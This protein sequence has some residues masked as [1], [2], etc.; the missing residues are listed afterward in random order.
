MPLFILNH[1]Q[2]YGHINV[3]LGIA[4]LLAERGHKPYFLLRKCF[5]DRIKDRGYHFRSLDEPEEDAMI[6]KKDS[7]ALQMNFLESII[8]TLKK[9]TIEQLSVVYDAEY[10][11]KEHKTINDSFV[12][13]L[14]HETPDIIILSTLITLPAVETCGIPWIYFH[15]PSPHL[16]YKNLRL[17]PPLS[18]FSSD[19]DANQIKEFREALENWSAKPAAIWSKYLAEN[20]VGPVNC[21]FLNRESPYLNLYAYPR[22]LDFGDEYKLPSTYYRMDNAIRQ[23]D[24]SE[25]KIPDTFLQSKKGKLIYVSMGSW[26]SGI[27]EVMQKLV[28]ILA[29]SPNRFIISR[30]PKHDQYELADNMWGER[31]LN[32]LRVLPMVDL[33]I[34]HGGNNSTVECLYFG[35]P[36]IVMPCFFDQHDNAQR[37]HEK[38]L[39]IKMNPFQVDD[40]KL[41][42]AIEKLLTDDEIIAR[43]QK[44]SQELKNSNSREEVVKVLEQ[45][46]EKKVSPF[47][48]V[49]DVHSNENA[50]KKLDLKD[51]DDLKDKLKKSVVVGNNNNN[52]N[53]ITEKHLNGVK[54]G[55]SKDD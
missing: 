17:I 38:G 16:L 37:I 5:E 26:F 24:G 36:M 6:T 28:N 13:L 1:Y 29:K 52:H 32:Q 20:G 14:K 47:Q 11:M 42:D 15:T 33:V 48:I 22:I 34:T 10:L 23:D 40:D 49:E 4:D 18:G 54:N 53:I 41:L 39:G 35:K 9:P 30:G 25:L 46:A 21:G 3:A 55:K 7:A 19:T 8:P 51:E 27:V 44:V 43:L 12:K 50:S 2:R 45:I 31:F